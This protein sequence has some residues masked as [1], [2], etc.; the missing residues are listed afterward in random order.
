MR[1][2][3]E[4][5][6]LIFSLG[7]ACSCTQTLRN[8]CLQLKSYPFDWLFGS[9]FSNRIDILINDFDRFLKKEDLEFYYSERSIKCDAYKNKYNNLVFNHDFPTG[10]SLDNSYKDIKE[11][12]DRRICRL[13]TEINNAQSILITYIE[14]PDHKTLITDEIL[15]DA[16]NKLQTKYPLKQIAILCISNDTKYNYYNIKNG[17]KRIFLNYKLFE[18]KDKAFIANFNQL[19]KELN[20]YALNISPL[21]ISK[22]KLMKFISYLI[23]IKSIREKYRKKY[24]VSK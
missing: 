21:L 6:D 16:H 19:N 18:D 1:G 13:L 23:P 4:K 2:N 22:I 15:I 10:I 8:C 24:H 5:Y 12:Y 11:K 7:E 9:S 3:K 14:T 17:I 20:R